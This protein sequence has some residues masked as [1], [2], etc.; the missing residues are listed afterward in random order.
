MKIRRKAGPAVRLFLCSAISA[1]FSLQADELQVFSK[2]QPHMGTEFTLQTYAPASEKDA[3]AAAFTKALA[4][5][6]ELEDAVEMA[7]A[8]A[9]AVPMGGAELMHELGQERA[10]R[11]KTEAEIE[12]L[13]GLVRNFNLLVRQSAGVAGYHLNGAI[14]T[15]EELHDDFGALWDDPYN[16][17]EA[18]SDD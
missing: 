7:R 3:V 16:A 10:A 2:T 18:R 1:A 17:R 11:K 12:R 15:W 6:E 13:R 8:D 4:R 5:V 9:N 14:A